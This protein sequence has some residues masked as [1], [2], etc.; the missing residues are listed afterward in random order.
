MSKPNAHRAWLN[1]LRSLSVRISGGLA[2]DLP[3]TVPNLQDR[4]AALKRQIIETETTTKAEV[5]AQ[6]DLL[7]DLAWNDMVRCLVCS[8]NKSI[9]K[10]WPK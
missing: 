10:L 8:I 9:E 6:V 2:D 7:K 1:E 4:V 3:G 5:Q